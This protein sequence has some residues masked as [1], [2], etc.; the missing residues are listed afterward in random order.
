MWGCDVLE[1]PQDRGL[2]SQTA[3]HAA[4]AG[5]FLATGHGGG[6]RPHGRTRSSFRLIW[7]WRCQ[8]R[9]GECARA[10]RA[11]MVAVGVLWRVGAAKSRTFVCARVSLICETAVVSGPRFVAASRR[12][13]RQRTRGWVGNSQAK[14]RADPHPARQSED[15]S[16]TG[17]LSRSSTATG[18]SSAGRARPARKQRRPGTA[19]SSRRDT[20][21]SVSPWEEWSASATC[22]PRLL[23]QGGRR[24]RCTSPPWWMIRR[25]AD[26]DEP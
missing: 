2:A 4:V 12:D 14:R 17:S 7:G 23:P 8:G 18:T 24:G 6:A 9:R 13:F 25:A 21:A 11:V 26:S 20:F 5:P 19:R 16:L 3:G 22:P 15:N 10:R 1:P